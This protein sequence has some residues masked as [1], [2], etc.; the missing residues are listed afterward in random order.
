MTVI[1]EVSPAEAC[2]A[3][4]WITPLGLVLDRLA[5]WIWIGLTGCDFSLFSSALFWVITFVIRG[6]MPWGS[7]TS[8]AKIVWWKLR[9]WGWPVVMKNCVLLVS[10]PALA[11]A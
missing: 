7:E 10:G 2:V 8:W 9:L 3:S 11:I 5:F 4:T 1:V 6:T